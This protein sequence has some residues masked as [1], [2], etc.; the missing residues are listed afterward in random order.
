LTDP[1]DG[2]DGPN[3]GYA[4][5]VALATADEIPEQLHPSWLL[6]L[7]IAV[8]NQ[9]AVDGRFHLRA[10]KFGVFLFGA[11][12]APAPYSDWLDRTGTLGFLIGLP[13]PEAETT[14]NLPAGNAVLLMAKLLRP[15][16]YE[17][18]ASRGYDGARI[19][20]ERFGMDGSYHLSSLKRA[21][22]V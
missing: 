11:P 22:V 1:F 3:I 4:V 13:I 8:S 19:L 2:V 14:M 5:E 12:G 15:A 9:A 7:T 18:V 21:S 20:V 6:D 17:F 10:A 16:E